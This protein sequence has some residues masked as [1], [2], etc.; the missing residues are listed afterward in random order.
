MNL[1]LA[2]GRRGH[3]KAAGSIPSLS[4]SLIPSLSDQVVGIV[5]YRGPYFGIFDTLKEKNPWKKDKAETHRC[6]QHP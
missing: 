6:V 2:A 4:T 5:A 3:L 1:A